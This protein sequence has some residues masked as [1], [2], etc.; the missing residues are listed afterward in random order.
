MAVIEHI[1]GDIHGNFDEYLALEKTWKEE[2]KKTGDACHITCTGDLMNGGPKSYQLFKHVQNHPG[3]ELILGNNDE[4]FCSGEIVGSQFVNMG[5]ADAISCNAAS[6]VDKTGKSILDY[7]QTSPLLNDM[8][9]RGHIRNGGGFAWEKEDD[10]CLANAMMFYQFYFKAELE[11]PENQPLFSKIQTGAA[12]LSN[13]VTGFKPDYTF[14]LSDSARIAR[15]DRFANVKGYGFP[16]LHENVF[17]KISQQIDQM[18]QKMKT[19]IF[20]RSRMNDDPAFKEYIIEGKPTSAT[21][22]SEKY[23]KEDYGNII[24][25]YNVMKD[26]KKFFEKCPTSKIVQAD[27]INIG[28]SHA[29]S[30]T[31]DE[32]G[33]F[34]Q[35]QNYLDTFYLETTEELLTCAGAFTDTFKNANHT[36]GVPERWDRGHGKNTDLPVR[37]ENNTVKGLDYTIHGHVPRTEETGNSVCSFDQ[38][39]KLVSVNLDGGAKGMEKSGNSVIRG[40]KPASETFYTVDKDKIVIKSTVENYRQMAA[41]QQFFG[42][43]DGVPANVRSS[44]MTAARNNASTKFNSQNSDGGMV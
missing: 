26:M 3:F 31:L 39:G 23:S 30:F 41:S 20:G 37:D 16:P 4:F 9:P 13:A 8:S 5:V 34:I 17:D 18:Q 35:N 32:Q 11:K 43:R 15:M 33:N 42:K 25:L 40:L 44:M 12:A 7:Y 19:G 21:V 14:S 24:F 10:I 22:Q 36:D 2:C 27:G 6:G 29:G 38:K 28:L 1:V